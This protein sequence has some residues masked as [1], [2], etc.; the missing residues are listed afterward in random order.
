MS[1]YRTSQHRAWN[2]NEHDCQYGY[3]C[4]HSKIPPCSEVG[5]QTAPQSLG[6]R[7]L[8]VLRYQE[9]PIRSRMSARIKT[10]VGGLF[11]DFGAGLIWVRIQGWA[12]QVRLEFTENGSRLEP[13]KPHVP[14]RKSLFGTIRSSHKRA[15]LTQIS[16]ERAWVKRGREVAP[17]MGPRVLCTFNTNVPTSPF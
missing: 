1:W 2:E 5:H 10:F 7:W 9:R 4:S 17:K 12:G 16:I 6:C 15:G 3:T 11:T 14:Q 8:T 13:V